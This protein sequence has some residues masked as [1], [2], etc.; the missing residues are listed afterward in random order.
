MKKTILIATLLLS[1]FLFKTAI[2]QVH[3]RLNV[4]I[5]SQ[6]V[7]GP[8]GYDHVEYYYMPDIDAFYSVPRQQY[9]Y[10]QRGRWVFASSLPIR[11]HNYDLYSGYKVVIN[12]P[13]PYRHAE[14]Y[15]SQYGSY[16]DRHDQEVIRNSHDPRYFEIKDHPEHNK[17]KN[18]HNSG[19]HHNQGNNRNRHNKRGDH[20]HRQ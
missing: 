17:W 9:I 3:V 6:P 1:G 13:T 11:Y 18:D 4:N 8:V 2:A 15:R 20:N 19:N 14:T 12:D 10:Q 16:K 7:W 5:G